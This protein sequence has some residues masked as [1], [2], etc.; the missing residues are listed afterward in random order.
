MGS[1]GESGCHD[2]TARPC[3]ERPPKQ[4]GAD[5]AGCDILLQQRLGRDAEQ[6][7][8]RLAVQERRDQPSGRTA[9]R[10]PRKHAQ[11]SSTHVESRSNHVRFH[12]PI[13]GQG[14][15]LPFPRASVLPAAAASVS[16]AC[17]HPV[18]DLVTWIEPGRVAASIYPH[19]EAALAALAADGATLIVNLHPRAHPPER[20]A[21]HGTREL[22]L[23]VEDFTPPTPGQLARG[24]ATIADELAAGGAVVVHCTAGLGRTGTLLACWLVSRGKSPD[25]AIA[26]IRAA[27]PGSIETPAQEEA[28]HAFARQ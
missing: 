3:P 5:E 17:Y 24:V 1:G 14:K 10:R 16:R 7:R 2:L 13:C 19:D 22:H 28:V 20:L 9:G 23:P 8:D 4:L 6:P 18:M 11:Q 12:C 15:P 25:E 27:R 21:V 26:A